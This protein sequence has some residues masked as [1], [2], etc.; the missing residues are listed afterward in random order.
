MEVKEAVGSYEGFS[1]EERQAFLE[2]LK[3]SDENAIV[4]IERDDDISV[5]CCGA[6]KVIQS[7]S[8]GRDGATYLQNG[9]TE[10]WKTITRWVEKT[11][12]RDY[13]GKTV[14][15]YCYSISAPSFA[16]ERKRRFS[17]LFNDA[18]GLT[19]AE[20]AL[21]RAIGALGN[22]SA[23]IKKYLDVI[24]SPEMRDSAIEV[25]DKLSIEIHHDLNDEV[26][27]LFK[28]R[29]FTSHAHEEAL[30]NDALGWLK[31]KFADQSQR[32]IS[33]KICYVDFA[34]YVRI[35]AERYQRDPLAETIGNPEP[36]EVEQVRESNPI[37]LRQ[38]FAIQPASMD[39]DE[40]NLLAVCN[41]LRSSSQ[42]VRWVKEDGLITR[43]AVSS[44]QRELVE[45]WRLERDDVMSDS[46]GLF[47]SEQQGRKIYIRTQRESRHKVLAGSVPPAFVCDGQ[48][49]E[50]ADVEDIMTDVPR[51]V[52]N[53]TFVEKERSIVGA[54]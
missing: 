31:G 1:V 38:L 42:I 50:L 45:A 36:E 12:Q 49:H 21:N 18:R 7:K 41:W 52:W 54:G 35:A 19:E 46:L 29:A 17:S 53:P 34:E 30:Y 39:Q 28:A 23:R 2:L 8:S 11:H 27:Q 40:E 5:D 16:S 44:Y 32:G 37:F 48:L 25:I 20:D 33:P 51:I 22:S 15:C 26:M 24:F 14:Y 13:G 43:S 6:L 47:S 9:S 3:T 4:S 10:F